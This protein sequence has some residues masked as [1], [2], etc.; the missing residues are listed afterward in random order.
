MDNLKKYIFLIDSASLSMSKY[1]TLDFMWHRTKVLTRSS[2]IKSTSHTS[3]HLVSTG[4]FKWLARL[5][6]LSEIVM[7]I[8]KSNS[9]QST[10]PHV[11]LKMS[12]IHSD[13][14]V[15]TH[16]ERRRGGGDGITV[17]VSREE[18]SLI[19]FLFGLDPNLRL[20]SVQFLTQ[21][22]RENKSLPSPEAVTDN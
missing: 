21:D 5:Y 13:P 19:S 20:L 7:C 14:G 22:T 18:V 15:D 4:I 12:S 11:V 3:T 2:R 1:G 10:A 9:V 8:T 16:R 6:S 17:A